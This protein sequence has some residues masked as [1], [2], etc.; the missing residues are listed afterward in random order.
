MISKLSTDERYRNCVTT[1]RS[2]GQDH[3]LRWWGELPDPR[4]QHLLSEIE[5]IPWDAVEPLV[6]THV[7]SVPAKVV[8]GELLPPQVYPRSPTPTE[9]A[10]YEEAKRLGQKLLAEAKVAAFTVAGGQGTRLGFEGPKGCVTVSPVR[11]KTLFQLFAEMIK[12]AGERSGVRIPW[13]VMTNPAIHEQT[14][15]FLKDHEFF[16]LDGDDV[17]VFPQAMLPVFDYQGKILLSDKH[18][19]ALAPDGHGGSLK[20]LVSSGAL[21]DMQSRGI[22]IISYFQVDNPLVKPFDAL[23]IGLHALAESD[24]STK[25]AA[26]VDDLERVGNVC[27]HGGRVTVVEYTD[28]PERLARERNPDGS[29]RFNVGN[30]AIHA[31]N[32]SFVQRII[33][34]TFQLPYHRAEK[35]TTWVD[36]HGFLRTPPR[37]NSV[38]VETFV[39]DAL[40]LARNPLLL[41]VDRAEEFSPVKNARGVDSVETA[42]RDQIRRAARW[43]QAAGA[44]IPRKPDGEPDVTIEIAP[45]YA[46]DP[47]DLKRCTTVA[48][49]VDSGETVY[50]S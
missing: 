32:V 18:R 41:E 11:E 36:E 46:L 50:I 20:A 7:L 30:L 21:R 17:F 28:F 6:Q 44:R 37:P 16:G 34:D 42:I 40:P 14:V 49:T 5:S 8:H 19:L 43:L 45:L 33:A 13:Y 48:P 26:K 35:V 25:V 38:K 12:A 39:F 27:L 31:L 4:R 24:M 1:L 10:L 47:D 23:F 15:G 3:V 22:E 9:A 2:R 29:R